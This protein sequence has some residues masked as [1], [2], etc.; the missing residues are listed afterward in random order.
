VYDDKEAEEKYLTLDQ[1][2]TVLKRLGEQLPGTN[3]DI[4]NVQILCLHVHL[5]MGEP[6]ANIR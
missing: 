1:L 5:R 6:G 2:G 4:F 3:L